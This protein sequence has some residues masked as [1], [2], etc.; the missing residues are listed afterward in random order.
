[1]AFVLAQGCA[2]NLSK[3]D[4]A[5]QPTSVKLSSFQTVS[6][7]AVEIAPDFAASSANQKA[8]KKINELLSNKM[9]MV[10]SGLQEASNSSG[11]TGLLIE[12]L[13]LEIKFIGGAARFWAGALA[14]SSAVLMEVTFRNLSTGNVV[15]KPQFYR[16]ANAF[17]GGFT[18][19]GTDNAML[20]AIAT[21]AVDYARLN[22]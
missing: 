16:A 6:L 17:A 12:P 3:P 18:M 9:P 10:F 21:D 5:P 1:L 4:A 15:G 2:T 7:K 13:I 11:Q 14:G 22:F 19:G 8:A 20:E